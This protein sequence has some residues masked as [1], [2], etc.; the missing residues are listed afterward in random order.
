MK[1]VLQNGEDEKGYERLGGGAKKINKRFRG[2][3]TVHGILFKW[4]SM[5]PTIG[6]HRTQRRVSVNIAVKF[7][8]FMTRG[9]DEDI[10]TRSLKF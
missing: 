5:S 9:E 6:R 1:L 3:A 2:G 10:E 8:I 7:K 4:V